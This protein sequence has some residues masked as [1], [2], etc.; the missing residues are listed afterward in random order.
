MMWLFVIAA[1]TAPVVSS[2]PSDTAAADTPVPGV[3]VSSAAA[4]AS[5]PQPTATWRLYNST[6][7]DSESASVDVLQGAAFSLCRPLRECCRMPL[8]RLVWVRMYSFQDCFGPATPTYRLGVYM[9]KDC[10][11]EP[12]VS[13]TS[14]PNGDCTTDGGLSLRWEAPPDA[15]PERVACVGFKVHEHLPV[16]D[17]YVYEGDRCEGS[18]VSVEPEES[19]YAV[20]YKDYACVPER[21]GGSKQRVALC[22]PYSSYM[23]WRTLFFVDAACTVPDPARDSNLFTVGEC[24]ATHGGTRSSIIKLRPPITMPDVCAYLTAYVNATVVASETQL[25]ALLPSNAADSASALGWLTAA[26]VV[27]TVL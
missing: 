11:G 13:M 17:E 23:Q 9:T 22:K 24:R 1:L 3:F 26:L 5:L 14:V 18:A 16:S 15:V 25:E 19:D 7:C 10:T 2:D 27:L 21:D 12:N 6:T 8:D 4:D 20:S